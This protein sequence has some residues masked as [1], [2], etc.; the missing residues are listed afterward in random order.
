MLID[1]ALHALLHPGASPRLAIGMPASVRTTAGLLNVRLD[2]ATHFGIAPTHP[3][4]STL[5]NLAGFAEAK[6][7]RVFD[8]TV[9]RALR[10]WTTFS[11]RVQARLY[12]NGRVTFKHAAAFRTVAARARGGGPG[13]ETILRALERALL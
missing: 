5:A 12:V 2:L 10:L 6:S 4:R 7:D 11:T 3:P 13:G 8:E 1:G 9:L